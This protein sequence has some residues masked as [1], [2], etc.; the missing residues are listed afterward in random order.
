MTGAMLPHFLIPSIRVG[1]GVYWRA[2]Q[3][4]DPNQSPGL[5]LF[6]LQS[7]RR[8]PE[9]GGHTQLPRSWENATAAEPAAPPANKARAGNQS[10]ALSRQGRLLGHRGCTRD[11]PRLSGHPIPAPRGGPHTHGEG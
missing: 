1:V 4:W 11:L 10:G 7:A 2:W 9:G 5:S 6:K 3:G 8:P